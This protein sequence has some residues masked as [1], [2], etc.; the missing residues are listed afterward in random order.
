MD[1]GIRTPD[2]RDHNPMLYPTELRPPHETPL[3]MVARGGPVK[4]SQPCRWSGEARRGARAVEGTGLETRQGPCAPRGFESPSLR[5]YRC[6]NRVVGV[7]RRD[8][9]SHACATITRPGVRRSPRTSAFARRGARGKN[10]S[11]RRSARLAGH[12]SPSAGPPGPSR[13]DAGPPAAG[14]STADPAPREAVLFQRRH[15]Q[16]RGESAR[17]C[18]S[19]HAFVLPAFESWQ[20]G[21]KLRSRRLG[22]GLGVLQDYGASISM[23]T[24]C[25]LPS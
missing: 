10:L 14:G 13:D 5:H 12:R 11:S 20:I 2:P 1:E 7:P 4:T 16:D 8:L 6:E 23:T 15:P 17:A 24:W 22:P 18:S 9:C 19:L 25:V 21:P 3:I